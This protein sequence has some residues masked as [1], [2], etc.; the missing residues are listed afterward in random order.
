[1]VDG[2]KSSDCIAKK[3]NKRIPKVTDSDYDKELNI[4][5]KKP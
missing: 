1:M 4:E 5:R 3:K 2:S